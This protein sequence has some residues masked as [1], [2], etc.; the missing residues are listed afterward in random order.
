MKKLDTDTWFFRAMGVVGDWAIVSVLWLVC[1]LPIITA[2]ASTLALF[3]VAHKMAAKQ[4][5]TAAR[6]FFRAFKR[7]FR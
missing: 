2:G 1:S 5:Y 7:D 3:A 4:D 6:D